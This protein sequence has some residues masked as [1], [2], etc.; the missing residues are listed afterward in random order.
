MKRNLI[1]AASLS[2]ALIP[3][4]AF[5]LGLGELTLESALNQPFSAKIE[6]SGVKAGE[7]EEL[8]V[9][10][11]TIEEHE[12]SGID[13]P[14]ILSSLRFSV[15]GDNGSPYIKVTSEQPITEPI[16]NFLL[17]VESSQSHHLREYAVFLDPVVLPANVPETPVAA[18]EPSNRTSPAPSPAKTESETFSPSEPPAAG[19]ASE[20]QVSRG[21]T[22]WEIASKLRPVD[23]LSVDQY[24][25]A[26]FRANSEAFFRANPNNLM[27]GFVLRVPSFDEVD[28]IS[29]S[30]A[31]SAM[32][33]YN[34]E[35]RLGKVRA[36][37]S[38]ESAGAATGTIDRSADAGEPD[39]K[40]ATGPSEQA[41][42]EDRE[43]VLRLVRE[44]GTQSVEDSA[45]QGVEEAL[46]QTALLSEELDAKI[47]ENAELKDRIADLEGQVTKLNKLLEMQS[48]ELAALTQTP[49]VES[50]ETAEPVAKA[51]PQPNPPPAVSPTVDTRRPSL[52][53]KI[54]EQK[55]FIAIGAAGLGVLLLLLLR[56]RKSEDEAAEDAIDAKVAGA[57]EK[58]AGDSETQ[59]IDDLD[60]SQ[61]EKSFVTQ[62]V[63]EGADDVDPVAE[64]EVYMTYGRYNQAEAILADAIDSDDDRMSTKI[65]LLEV[66]YL[67]KKAAEFEQ[68]AADLSAQCGDDL[69]EQWDKV[70]AWGYE[71][72]P[73]NQLFA[74]AALAQ[75]VTVE[76]D[77]VSVDDAAILDIDLEDESVVTDAVDVLIDDYQSQ[78]SLAH[79]DAVD[80]IEIDSDVSA[81][82]S[83][84][85]DFVDVGDAEPELEIDL[86]ALEEPAEEPSINIDFGEAEAEDEI[87]FEMPEIEDDPLSEN[88]E[89]DSM[90]PLDIEEPSV[91]SLS[92]AADLD[93][94]EAS[95]TV[96]P[97]QME[98]GEGGELDLVDDL[99]VRDNDSL[100]ID[101]L[102]GE[103]DI[104]DVAA[105]VA[106][107][108]EVRD[109]DSFNLDELTGEFNIGDVESAADD[110]AA[111]A[112][113]EALEEESGSFV[114]DVS[115]EFSLSDLEYQGLKDEYQKFKENSADEPA[116]ETD[117]IE[118]D[119][120]DGLFDDA[121]GVDLD[122]AD[123]SLI[124]LDINNLD[125]SGDDGAELL[126]E[127]SVSTIDAVAT[128]L[129]LMKAYVEMGNHDEA[130]KI[131]AD[132]L[133]VGSETQKKQAADFY[134]QFDKETD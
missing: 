116:A 121:S 64:A 111:E 106:D 14:A 36:A 119:D 53:D 131:Y 61:P 21:D 92:V 51:Q 98:P 100:N 42:A 65:K 94:E 72:S 70:L 109:D 86:S 97:A 102:S 69:P 80:D 8:S 13:R 128:K 11:A 39:T 91:A 18:P 127:E 120:D 56:R 52:I 29:Y 112:S 124:E 23:G 41:A 93:L 89:I 24:V 46:A 68:N 105:T 10:L 115:M 78:A 133:A 57:G 79:V 3:G 77:D 5:A 99:K 71:L 2:A 54:L 25:I 90:N 27:E 34:E 37:T 44:G 108:I 9:S 130:E 125:L 47:Q 67:Q 107:D 50:P 28:K 110:A 117:S 33:S 85:T 84:V 19:S 49:G 82:S 38:V 12:K 43:G 62:V 132:V 88:F 30:E 76:S 95:V 40:I 123:D 104:G 1:S 74:S 87:S 4:G 134:A 6:L 96:I 73:T 113:I 20:W 63:E 103:F 83:A 17:D 122:L 16:L 114:D 48:Q 66:L 75:P 15:V 35:W 101:D 32:V 45:Q 22:L 59:G 126:D 60:V 58:T 31:R 129:D 26:L 81:V 55:Q 7:L 118:L